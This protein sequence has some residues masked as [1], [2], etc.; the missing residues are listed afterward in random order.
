MD[1]A[2]MGAARSKEARTL[3]FKFGPIWARGGRRLLG[4]IE[5]DL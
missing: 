5:M 4:F 2:T 3:S 1:G